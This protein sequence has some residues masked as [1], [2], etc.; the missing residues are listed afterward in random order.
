MLRRGFVKLTK[1]Q[2]QVY[3]YVVLGL[4]TFIVLEVERVTLYSYSFGMFFSL[5]S[6]LLIDYREL[7]QEK[8]I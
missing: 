5:L 7:F 8:S 4:L 1:V 6:L 3:A 2:F